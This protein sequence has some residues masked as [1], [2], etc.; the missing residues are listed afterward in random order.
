MPGKEPRGREDR[1]PP[2]EPGSRHVPG[3]SGEFLIHPCHLAFQCVGLTWTRGRE[4]DGGETL[5]PAVLPACTQLED[6]EAIGYAVRDLD[7]LLKQG[8]VGFEL[9]E[10]FPRLARPPGTVHVPADDA[11]APASNH[12]RHERQLLS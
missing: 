8:D 4:H 11:E 6:G 3:K 2:V 5:L 12:R 10:V 9:K 7:N 1:P